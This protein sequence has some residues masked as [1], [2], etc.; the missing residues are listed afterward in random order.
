VG[1]RKAASNKRKHGITFQEAA[2]VFG[3]PLAITFSD[4]DHSLDEARYLTFG[5]SVRRQLVV[6]SHTFRVDRI[7]IISS[8]R[9]T[10]RERKIYETG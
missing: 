8:R 10:P 6:V 3:G 9:L 1:C 4:P 7:R 2:T 5:E